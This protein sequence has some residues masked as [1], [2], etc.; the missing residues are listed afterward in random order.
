MSAERNLDSLEVLERFYCAWEEM[1]GGD[2]LGVLL[3]DIET[4]VGDRWKRWSVITPDD[5][6][7]EPTPSPIDPAQL[8]I[9]DT[10]TPLTTEESR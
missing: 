3:E 7:D 2:A 8:E 9:P 4:L 10:S 6:E 5:G 1:W